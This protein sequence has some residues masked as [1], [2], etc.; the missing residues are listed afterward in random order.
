MRAGFLRVLA[1][2]PALA[3]SGEPPL[4]TQEF[5]DQHGN[6]DALAR[7]AGA[8]VVAVVVGVKRLSMI[9]A[10]ERDLAAR[11]PGLRFLNVA[12]L[13]RDV[14]VDLERTAL[15]LRKRV[16]PGVNVLLDPAGAWAG[17]FAL[18]TTLPNLLVF[19]PDGALVARFRGRW[20]EPLAAEV[21]AAVPAGATP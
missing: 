14:P 3:L 8:P 5:R 10:W 12:D 15:T 16:P 7:Y 11:V 19:G 1:L 17:E 21:A 6:V 18:D 20:S 2:V 4:A 13:P 9:E